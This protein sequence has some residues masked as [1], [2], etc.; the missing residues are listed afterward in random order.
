M[1]DGRLRRAA[2][3]GDF[4]AKMLGPDGKAPMKNVEYVPNDGFVPTW[5]EDRPPFE[6]IAEYWA[7]YALEDQKR[8]YALIVLDVS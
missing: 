1:P 4:R 3:F 5:F 8:S 2:V 7:D 6:P